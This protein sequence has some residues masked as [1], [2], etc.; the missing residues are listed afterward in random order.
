RRKGFTEEDRSNLKK[1]Y[2]VIFRNGAPLK[3]ALLQLETDFSEDKNIQ[4]LVDFIKASNRGI[5]R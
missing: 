1:A 5:T 2:R 4:Y 3:D